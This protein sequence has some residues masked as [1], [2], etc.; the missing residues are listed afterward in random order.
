MIFAGLFIGL[1][2]DESPQRWS[3][4]GGRTPNGWLISS[5]PPHPQVLFGIFPVVLCGFNCTNA[6]PGSHPLYSCRPKASCRWKVQLPPVGKPRETQF[7]AREGSASS[8]ENNI[9]LIEDAASLQSSLLERSPVPPC[10]VRERTQLLLTLPGALA[11]SHLAPCPAQG[12][13][14]GGAAPILQMKK[15]RP[16]GAQ[17]LTRPTQG[18][19]GNKGRSQHLNSDPEGSEGMP[20]QDRHGRHRWRLLRQLFPPPLIQTLH[21]P[22]PWAASADLAERI[23]EACADL[24]DVTASS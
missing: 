11:V 7:F 21:P 18:H 6:L 24:T 20:T 15:V 19:S 17:G 14:P 16:K 1:D 12:D 23:D 2:T 13:S 4:R 10:T 5:Y 3:Q 22:R 9:H 8:P